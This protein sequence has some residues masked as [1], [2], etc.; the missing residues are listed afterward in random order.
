MV[1]F[2][3][4]L[5][6]FFPRVSPA[7]QRATW[8]FSSLSQK[9]SHQ[10]PWGSKQTE[11]NGTGGRAQETAGSP[12]WVSGS[13]VRSTGFTR[14][15]ML[16]KRMGKNGVHS[17]LSLPFQK[18]LKC[19][20]SQAFDSREAVRICL[21]FTHQGISLIYCYWEIGST[22]SAH[23]W[24]FYSLLHMERTFSFEDSAACFAFPGPWRCHG[25]IR[26]LRSLVEGK[27]RKS[28]QLIVVRMTVRGISV[29]LRESGV[30][31]PVF[32]FLSNT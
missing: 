24:L 8:D 11:Q 13:V 16:K 9:V 19:S 32:W 6:P 4:P 28:Q 22:V 30:D 25:V 2:L 15:H 7:S 31:P 5:T 1:S 10:C 23:S 20:C 14:R 21:L 3:L 27:L 12:R 17:S 29:F 18:P 26:W